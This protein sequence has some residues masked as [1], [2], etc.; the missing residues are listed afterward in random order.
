ML[1]GF[2]ESRQFH[3]EKMSNG[4]LNSETSS[5][6]YYTLFTGYQYLSVTGRKLCVVVGS[7]HA[8]DNARYLLEGARR[9]ETKFAR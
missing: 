1:Q 6:A 8:Y 3:N 7:Q 4:K 5:Q 9:G 2:I